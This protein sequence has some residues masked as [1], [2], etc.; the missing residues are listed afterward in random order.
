MSLRHMS[1]GI[2]GQRR[3]RSACAAEQS[4]HRGP[5]LSANRFIGYT[6]T[7]ER[8]TGKQRPG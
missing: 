6:G 4:D 5:S 2:Y 1:S 3:P 7:T 8:M